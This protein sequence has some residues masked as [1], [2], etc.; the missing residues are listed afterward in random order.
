MTI[1]VDNILDGLNR[2][3]D[4]GYWTAERLSALQIINLSPSYWSEPNTFL[5]G[6]PVEI[7]QT[8]NEID[9][10]YFLDILAAD[11][12]ID[13]K[14]LRIATNSDM[15]DGLALSELGRLFA[16]DLERKSADPDFDGLG[17]RFILVYLP[18]AS[19]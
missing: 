1:L 7:R 14:G 13:V 19:K 3:E 5:D 8:Y 16:I 9:G 2:I 11:G 17:T 15:L 4:F 6:I 10:G 18:R 12:S